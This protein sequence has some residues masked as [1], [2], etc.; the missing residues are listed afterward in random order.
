MEEIKYLNKI[1]L[2]HANHFLPHIHV[3]LN[4]YAWSREN[5]YGVEIFGAS[6]CKQISGM[7]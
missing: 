6:K 5:G 3:I 4:L 7:I 1:L 2:I